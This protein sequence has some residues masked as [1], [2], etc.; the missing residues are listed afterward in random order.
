[1]E[2][3]PYCLDIQSIFGGI[4]LLLTTRPLQISYSS[5]NKIPNY[6]YLI[7]W[8]EPQHT[9]R[10]L[11]VTK[12]E[13]LFDF[14]FDWFQKISFWQIVL[15]LKHRF[16]LWGCSEI[17]IGSW[18]VVFEWKSNLTWT[19]SREQKSYLGLTVD[20]KR[21]VLA[22]VWLTFFVLCFMD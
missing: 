8:L 20:V 10:N 22:F 1:M 14:N 12:I 17:K 13:S 21:S 2:T 6:Q 3:I 4:Y 15:Y 11:I 5:E 7:H 16:I 18:K 9:L 19:L